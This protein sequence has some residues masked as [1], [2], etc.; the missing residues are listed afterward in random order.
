M[1]ITLPSTDLR[2]ALDHPLVSALFDRI[3]DGAI[4][5]SVA[6]RRVVAM[7]R[8]ARS[9]LGF[10]AEDALGCACKEVMNAPICRTDCVLTAALD[11]RGDVE[12]DT[13][14]RGP[15]GEKVVHARTR[16]L[17]VRGPDGTPL[18]G[19][20]LFSDLTEIRQ[21]EQQLG[22]RRS[23]QGIIGGSSP[24]ATLYDLIEQVAPYDLP[25]L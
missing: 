20:E 4:V 1:D 18:A 9:L 12:R 5:V 17:V 11:G 24:M 22:L 3:H 7:N 13:Y 23:F 8:R 21:L 2:A 14:F 25:V 6:E 19:V 16:V 10:T 15:D